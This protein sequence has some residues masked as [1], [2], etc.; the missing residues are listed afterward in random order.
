MSEAAGSLRRA[1]TETATL[2]VVIIGRNE[3][4]RLERCILSAQGIVDWNAMEL[5]YVD[6]GSTDG[7]PERAAQLGASMCSFWMATR[8]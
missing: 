6:S 7:S 5:L 2:S 4:E 3:G 1:A 8:F